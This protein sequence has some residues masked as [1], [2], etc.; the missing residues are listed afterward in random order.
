MISKYRSEEFWSMAK[1]PI[2]RLSWAKKKANDYEWFEKCAD[3]FDYFYGSLYD[4][5]RLE[6]LRLNYRLFNG[7][8][9]EAMASYSS[10]IIPDEEE[11]FY[12]D[13]N[14]RHHSV[15]DQI[16]KSY[17]GEQQMRPFSP[18][19]VDMSGYGVNYR[20]KKRLELLQQHIQQTIVDPITQQAHAEISMKHGVS[21]PFSLSPEEQQQFNFEVQERTKALTP[22]EIENYLR[23]EYKSPSEIQAQKLLDYLVSD[24]DVKFI[25]DQGFKH[26]IITGEEIYH[27]GIRHDKPTFTLVNPLGFTYSSS[28]NN[29]FIEDGEWAKYEEQIKFTDFFNQYGDLMKEKDLQKLSISFI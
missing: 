14:V 28:K 8:G 17:V 21:D 23:N 9:E 10:M 5:E 24:L 20:K 26:A 2:Q 22:K 7:Q 6:R 19:A 27:I 11:S 3:Y 16:A 29:Q 12:I 13:D 18:V 4:K 25:T 15:M 1:L